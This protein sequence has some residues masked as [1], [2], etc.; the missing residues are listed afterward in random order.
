MTLLKVWDNKWPNIRASQPAEVGAEGVLDVNAFRSIEVDKL[1]DTINYAETTIG[2]SILYRSLVQPLNSL[3]D[4]EGK[5]SA[6]KELQENADLKVSLERLVDNAKQDESYFYKLLFGTFVGAGS[7]ARSETE[8]EGYGYRQ[9]RR[10]TRFLREFVEGMQ[11][12]KGVKSQYLQE[13]LRST[14]DFSGSRIYS[15][16]SGPAY[17]TEKGI[18]CQLDRKKMTPAIIFNPRIFKP[19]LLLSLLTVLIVGNMFLPEDI[20][21]VSRGG[22][23]G[24]AIFIIPMMLIYFPIIGGFDRDS[25]IKPLREEYRTSEDVGRVL[26]TLGYVDEL[27][28]L[29]KYWEQ[30]SDSLVM[31]ELINSNHHQINLKNAK[32]PILS[33][34][35][36]GYV[37]NDFVLD[38]EKLALITGPNSGGKT[39]FCKTVTQV[40]LLAQIGSYVPA[41]SAILSVADKVFY[42][43]AEISQLEDGE[44]RFGTELK[45][46][47]DIFL[48]ST[49][50][51]LVVLDELSEGTTLEEKME[52]SVNILDGFYQKGCNTLLITHNHQLV[53]HF[54]GQ[55]IGMALQVEFIGDEPTHKLIQGI[56][57]VSHA[58]RVAKK[59]GFSKEDIAGYLADN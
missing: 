18:Q 53:D 41:A 1:F 50:K 20:V 56:S 10:G 12:L 19:L 27:L 17:I 16:M 38:G 35:D 26:D 37:G 47:R 15:L 30:N 52:T 39:A 54:I 46:T 34:P 29:I 32:N 3:S 11:Q 48:A 8:I 6:I 2:Q 55:K 7:T 57:R 33:S 45:R 21:N 28:S 25:A 59:I 14:K 43:A 9:Y 31:P 22:V 42:Q 5:Q 13:L 23:A 49:A 51:S 44:G 58:H 4:I 40:Q 36:S 24:I